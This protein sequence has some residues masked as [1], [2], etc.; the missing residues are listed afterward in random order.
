MPDAQPTITTTGAV[1]ASDATPS[2]PA[3]AAPPPAAP[4]A[5]ASA[6]VTVTPPVSGGEE[7]TLTQSQFDSAIEQ[8]LGRARRQWEAE[9]AKPEPTPEPA[10]K[11]EA[12]AKGETAPAPVVDT[13]AITA[14]VTANMDRKYA[15]RELKLNET[16]ANAIELQYQSEKPEGDAGTWVRARA[17]ELGFVQTQEAPPTVAPSDPSTPPA[18]DGG[19]PSPTPIGIP[20]ANNTLEF[21]QDYMAKILSEQIAAHGVDKG[22]R[23][24]RKIIR[25][26]FEAQMGNTMVVNPQGR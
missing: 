9:A 22:T 14:K 18:S 24:G 15:A 23:L 13:D 21:S 8:R 2:T 5:V 4:P 20:D 19:A 12:K 25:S 17:Q 26:K 1:T 3:A 7:R 6:P 11:P 16:Q 10:P